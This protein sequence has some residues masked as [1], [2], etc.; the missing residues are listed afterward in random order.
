MNYIFK[1]APPNWK[2]AAVLYE[3]GDMYLIQR[4]RQCQQNAIRAIGWTPNT[5]VPM[6]CLQRHV[7][8]DGKQEEGVGDHNRRLELTH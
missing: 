7:Q 6:S 3:D 4:L 2:Y 1:V 5:V 8:P